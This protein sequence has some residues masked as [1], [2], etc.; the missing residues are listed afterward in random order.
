MLRGV[1]PL[2]P[3]AVLRPEIIPYGWRTNLNGTPDLGLDSAVIAGAG[4]RATLVLCLCFRNSAVPRV[5]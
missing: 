5:A 3:V 2:G 1:L 4:P